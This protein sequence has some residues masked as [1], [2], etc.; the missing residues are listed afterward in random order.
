MAN[1]WVHV[2]DE[3]QDLIREHFPEECIAEKWSGPQQI[4]GTY[5]SYLLAGIPRAK[6]MLMPRRYRAR[7]KC[8]TRDDGRRLRW[9]ERRRIVEL[10]IAWLYWRIS[11]TG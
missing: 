9:Y 7:Q 5:N 11:C 6:G 8:E 1:K 10:L 3:Q 4:A 2:T